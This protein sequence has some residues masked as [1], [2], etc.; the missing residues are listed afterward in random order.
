MGIHTTFPCFRTPY[1]WRFALQGKLGDKISRM[2]PVRIDKKI[3]IPATDVFTHLIDMACI[4]HS[5]IQPHTGPFH[6]CGGPIRQMVFVPGRHR[7]DKS[8][9]KIGLQS[10]EKPSY[11]CI[12]PGDIRH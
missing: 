11:L 5:D 6:Q 12:A 1:P 3:D 4:W 8:V 7:H 9:G 10:R 2:Y